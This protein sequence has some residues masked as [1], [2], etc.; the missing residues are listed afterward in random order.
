MTKTKGVGRSWH[1][2]TELLPLALFLFYLPVLKG[3]SPLY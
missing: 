2:T 1:S 3:L